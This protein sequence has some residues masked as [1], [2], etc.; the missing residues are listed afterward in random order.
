[1]LYTDVEID[2]IHIASSRPEDHPSDED[3]KTEREFLLLKRHTQF[4]KDG[5]ESDFDVNRIFELNL[6]H[7]LATEQKKTLQFIESEDDIDDLLY[8]H[9]VM[10]RR[11]E[12]NF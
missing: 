3:V 2:S 5:E 6:A 11:V 8:K 1:M 7:D 12:L 9:H 4:N 10:L